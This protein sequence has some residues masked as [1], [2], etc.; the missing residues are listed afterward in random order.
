MHKPV[1]MEGGA[2]PGVGAIHIDEIEPTLIALERATGIDMRNNT[3][4]SVGKKQFSGDIDIAI[5]LSRD[6]IP[7]FIKRLEAS[8]KFIDITRGSVIMTK[9]KI[10]DYDP[11]KIPT[12][13]KPRTGFVQVDF[14]PGD[15]NW[16]KTYYHAPY[17]DKSDYSGYHRNLLLSITAATLNRKV[18]GE[19]LDDGRYPQEE[20]YV[21]GGNGLMRVLQKPKP[22]ATGDGYT[23]QNERVMIDGPWKT[24]DEIA[25]ELNLG[26]NEDLES[27]ET[28]NSAISR[29][30]DQ[31]TQDKIFNQFK[32]SL[33]KE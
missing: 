23:K 33:E 31:T 6:D 3:L 27:V 7:E 9:V 11:E 2:M 13:G 8:P 24:G 30:Y 5:N 15:I 17:E 21:F 25:R 14:M 16:M 12:N 28:I 26:S 20:R 32:K 4:G 10:V 29:N 18:V 1:I 19:P 22:K